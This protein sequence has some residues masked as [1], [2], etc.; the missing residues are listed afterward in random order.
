[1]S[2]DALAAQISEYICDV[3]KAILVQNQLSD[4]HS[5]VSQTWV[6][7]IILNKIIQYFLR[8]LYNP[9]NLN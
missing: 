2:F 8:M 6:T 4:R 5:I 1:M 9:I 7:G 3:M